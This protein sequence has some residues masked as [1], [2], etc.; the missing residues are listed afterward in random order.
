[1]SLKLKVS[2]VGVTGGR[3]LSRCG[4]SGRTQQEDSTAAKLP[5]MSMKGRRRL[6]CVWPDGLAVASGRTQQ[7]SR[8]GQGV[9]LLARLCH[10]HGHLQLPIFTLASL[11]G[12]GCLETITIGYKKE[13]KAQVITAKKMKITLP[14]RRLAID[15]LSGMR[16]IDGV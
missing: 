7:I 8:P 6:P 11:G 1:M 2:L 12:V 15:V 3:M 9:C 14:H 10:K 13:C 16:I 4:R 5:H